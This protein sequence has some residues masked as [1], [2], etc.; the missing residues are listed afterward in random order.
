MRARNFRGTEYFRSNGLCISVRLVTGREPN[1]SL[2][3]SY[4]HSAV[5]YDAERTQIYEYE[6]TMIVC[7]QDAL[8]SKAKRVISKSHSRISLC[9]RS[10]GSTNTSLRWR[11]LRGIGYD[12]V[13]IELITKRH[14]GDAQSTDFIRRLHLFLPTAELLFVLARSSH[15]SKPPGKKQG[16]DKTHVF[17]HF[18]PFLFDIFSFP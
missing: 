17:L 18:V 2:N 8:F 9:G 16:P 11:K 12:K 5:T 13:P 4:V 10:N 1:W 7:T 6:Y 3:S 15:E 14:H